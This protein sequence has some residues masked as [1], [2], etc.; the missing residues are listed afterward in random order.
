[1][2]A[3]LRDKSL[4]TI[5]VLALLTVLAHLHI[6]FHPIVISNLNENGYISLFVAKYMGSLMPT[7]LSW[8]FLFIIFIQAF[9]LNN[10]LNEWK[11]FQKSAFTTAAS[12][13]LIT[14]CYPEFNCFS[15]A[16]FNN[17]LVILFISLFARL[18]NNSKPNSLLF[19]IGFTISTSVLLFKPNVIFLFISFLALAIIRPFRLKEWFILLIGI[20]VPVYLLGSILFLSD[21]L[22]MIRYCIPYFQ[23]HRI[24]LMISVW[25]WIKSSVLLLALFIGINHWLPNYDRMVIH[26]RRNWIIL[27]LSMIILAGLPFILYKGC[28]LD[29]WIL[30]PLM[31]C[32]VSSLF[33]YP[34]RV[35]LPNL[36]FILFII[37]IAHTNLLMIGLIKK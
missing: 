27:F 12:Y 26:I 18:Y 20:I 8:L 28:F 10:V 37:L 14:A 6:F 7:V 3:L 23:I 9:L 22:D 13:I 19:N 30:L 25:F 1:M 21:K 32:F 4:I 35:L 15:P 36:I 34:K 24:V 16:L 29:F 33:L 5:F 11:M 17:F 31:A 2:I